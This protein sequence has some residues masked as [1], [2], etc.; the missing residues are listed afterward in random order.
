MSERSHPEQRSSAERVAQS[1]RVA[2]QKG[3]AVVSEVKYSGGIGVNV[4]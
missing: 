4:L 3:A 1:F 2:K